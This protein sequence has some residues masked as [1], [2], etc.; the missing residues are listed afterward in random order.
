MSAAT[1]TFTTL[2]LGRSAHAIELLVPTA[3]PIHT[4]SDLKARCFNYLADL[5]L[6]HSFLYSSA[7]LIAAFSHIPGSTYNATL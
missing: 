7:E 3:P 5:L 1:T 6:E 4:S 2:T